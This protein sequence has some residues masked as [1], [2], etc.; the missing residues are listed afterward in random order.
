MNKEKVINEINQF[1]TLDLKKQSY[2]DILKY[3]KKYAKVK[4]ELTA[5]QKVYKVAVI[6]SKS[7]QFFV[8]ILELMAYQKGYV[9]DIYEG[10]Y[11]GITSEI[12]DEHS[13]LYAFQP[14]YVFLLTHDSDIHVYPP[15]LSDQKTIDDWCHQTM[16]YYHTLWDK[17]EQLNC[18]V[19]QSSFVIPI[20]RQ[21][22]QLEGSVP[23]SKANALRLLNYQLMIEK[24]HH[25][26]LIDLEYIASYV[27]KQYWFDERN[28]YL[29][30]AGFSYEYL[31]IV[32]SY[33]VSRMCSLEGSVRKCVV[34]DLDNTLWGGVVG[35][36]GYDGINLNP[37]DAIGE[38]Y[39]AFQDYLLM[40]KQR[41]VILAVCSKNEEDVAKEAFIK[42][43][44]MRLSLDDISCF[45]AN[46]EDKASNIKKISEFLN[47]GIDSLVFVDD[48][49][50]EREIVKTFLPEVTVIDLPEDPALYVRCLNEAMCFDWHALTKED[51]TRSQTYQENL[52][53]QAL[54]QSFVDYDSY[55]ESLQMKGYVGE[56]GDNELERFIQLSNKSNQFNLRTVRLTE[57][58][59]HR[60]QAD[61]HYKLLY[62]TLSDCFSQYGL[63]SCI[64]LH[65]EN[66]DCFIENWL[67]SC[68]VLKRGVED[69]AF[70]EVLN[71]A[72]AWG[73]QSLIGE[74]IASKKNKM[75]KD[76]YSKM[77]F[78]KIDE[79]RYQIDVDLNLRKKVYI[80]GEDENECN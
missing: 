26:H 71:V 9:L 40:L 69:F 66:Q 48:N 17:L 58:D 72:K 5:H 54:Q 41:G 60:M 22:D 30:K 49:P 76:F 52:K 70:N 45:I 29:N 46:W 11:N 12:L 28:Y 59:V 24:P 4:D 3:A 27:G 50:A 2:L 43:P 7:I 8:K 64:I 78:Q 68:R 34:L 31:P 63:I 67:M 14:Q 44:F 18:V 1:L 77:G 51:I 33:Y 80:I 32:A 61:P 6:G 74:Y 36:D 53:R 56:V 39:L 20:E 79:N 73:C 21:L 38:A 75:V 25:V 62:V 13:P 55:L 37:N 57:A 47:I 15:L 16:A 35:D 65:K 23:Y 19:L 42:N 10:E